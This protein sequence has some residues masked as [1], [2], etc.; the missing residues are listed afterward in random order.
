MSLLVMSAG[1]ELI[2]GNKIRFIRCVCYCLG[3]C[4]F[5]L[6]AEVTQLIFIT[7]TCHDRISYSNFNPVLD[8]LCQI[9]T[10]F[11]YNC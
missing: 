1:L 10:N 2:K 5:I 3:T 9:Y 4:L 8:V 7:V 6:C 11:K